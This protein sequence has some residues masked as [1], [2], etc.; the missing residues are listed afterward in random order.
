[1]D[2]CALQRCR[3]ER[4]LGGRPY[5][6]DTR[7]SLRRA[8]VALMGNDESSRFPVGRKEGTHRALEVRVLENFRRQIEG[9][10]VMSRVEGLP[11][12]GRVLTRIVHH[13]E[14]PG[15]GAV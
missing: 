15:H 8:G 12:R 7:Y 9:I 3:L 13:I 1:M 6:I 5:L 10:V 11:H 2:T 4:L 14:H